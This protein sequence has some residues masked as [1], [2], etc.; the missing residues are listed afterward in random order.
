MQTSIFGVNCSTPAGVIVFGTAL[1]SSVKNSTTSA[2]RPRA[3]S[4]L[5]RSRR[6]SRGAGCRLLNARGRHRLWHLMARRLG[7][8]PNNCSTPAG[9]IVFGTCRRTSA[10]GVCVP[11]QRPRASSSL[12]RSPRLPPRSTARSAQR[13][14]ASSS[15]AHLRPV[16]QRRPAQLLNARG[17]HRLWHGFVLV[18]RVVAVVCSTPAGVIVFGTGTSTPCDSVSTLLNARGRHRLWHVAPIRRMVGMWYCSTPAGVIV[19]GTRSR[20]AAKASASSAQRPRASSSLAPGL[21]VGASQASSA[22]RPRASSS[23]AP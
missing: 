9:V 14:R 21:R 16:G 19:F 17:R 22:Q 10:P 15:L 18:G 2:Q 6:P 4:S 13:P 7:F 20:E 12:A 1:D 11:A 5:A 23:L 8:Q 3:S